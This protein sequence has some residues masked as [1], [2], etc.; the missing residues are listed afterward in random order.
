MLILAYADRFR[1]DLDELGQRI[2]Q[3]SCDRHRRALSD[4]EIR[5]LL[6][7]ELRRRVDRGSRL[8]D[9]DVLAVQ[10]CLADEIRDED[11]ALLRG[12]TVADRDDVDAVF[13]DEGGYLLPALLYPLLGLRRVDDGGVDDPPRTVDDT[14]LAAG[15]VAGVEPH[16]SLSPEGR[17]HEQ[18]LEVVAED[19]YRPLR[20]RVGEVVPDLPLDRRSDQ[21]LVA[22]GYR[23][24]HILLRGA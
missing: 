7:S 23:G 20:R 9:D 8:A 15:A 18:M 16:D 11:L 19:L 10:A 21:P 5:E 6:G 22:V 4:V 24:G 17:L 14:E 12:G 2:L 13:P 1:I 3:T